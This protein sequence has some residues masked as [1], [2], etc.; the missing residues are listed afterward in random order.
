MGGGGSEL[1]KALVNQISYVGFVGEH[2]IT[3]LEDENTVIEIIEQTRNGT[4]KDKFFA[5]CLSG[6]AY[7][8][9]GGNWT[10]ILLSKAKEVG[11]SADE[12]V[13]ALLSFPDSRATFDLLESLSVEIQ[14]AYWVSRP[15]RFRSK[16]DDLISYAIKKL[17][18]NGRAID[19]LVSGAQQWKIKDPVIV[20]E[21]LDQAI[22]ESNDNKLGKTVGNDSFWFNELFKWLRSQ[23]EIDKGQ[24]ARREYAYLPLLTGATEK[25]NLALH[26]ILA[27]DPNFFVR[28]VSDL[29]RASS[30]TS[31]SEPP[32]NSRRRAEFAWKLLRSWK[33]PPGVAPT[34]DVSS[35]KLNEWVEK[36]RHLAVEVDRTDI[37]DR[38]LGKVLF[39]FPSDPND[40]VWPHIELRRLLEKLQNENIEAGIELE[41]FN[42]RGV[43]NKE[44]FEGGT[45]ERVLAEKWRNI[46]LGLGV[47]WPRTQAMCARIASCW[48]S[49]A[50][51]EDERAEKQKLQLG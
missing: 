13:N 7:D 27:T 18:E 30:D 8:K 24:L 33:Q 49:D 3:H 44:L 25:T 43:V 15:R 28:V 20:F 31:E 39:Y 19:A 42:S 51:R 21:L 29:Y 4:D 9:F 38:E 2:L 5:R 23:P 36:A 1:I 6:S 48:D 11:W 46:A 14:Q 16:D 17:K 35:D 37:A 10:R 26:E 32:K 50:K 41:Q 47:R 22:E 12:I 45:Q 40:S 34:G